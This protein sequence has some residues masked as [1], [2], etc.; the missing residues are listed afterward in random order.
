MIGIF[1]ESAILKPMLLHKIRTS[2]EIFMCMFSSY[3]GFK[4]ADTKKVP[5][6]KDTVVERSFVHIFYMCTK[7]VETCKLTFASFTL[8]KNINE[9]N[10]TQMTFEYIMIIKS[11]F[12]I[13]AVKHF[14]RQS[15][16]GKFSHFFPGRKRGC[17]SDEILDGRFAGI[18][19]HLN[20]GAIRSRCSIWWHLEMT[21]DF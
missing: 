11:F 21:D 10:C 6:T 2:F 13:I 4:V 17:D 8:P 5:R 12:A 3:M 20:Y 7:I 1:R 14:L 16:R 18:N 15:F 19:V 9:M